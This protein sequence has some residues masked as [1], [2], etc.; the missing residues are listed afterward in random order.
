MVKPGADLSAVKLH[1]GGEIKKIKLDANGNLLIKS[2]AGTT[3]ET[4]PVTYYGDKL[5]ETK[6]SI[7]QVKSSYALKG[8]ELVFALPDGYDHSQSIV[9]DPFVSNTATL[10]GTGVNAGIAK[11]VDY[12]YA[13]NVYVTGGGDGSIYKLAKFDANGVLQWT[14][15]GA[16]TIPSW[17][18]GTIYGGWVVEKTTGNVYLGQGF[19]PSGGHRVIRI[20]TIGVYDNYITNANPSF[21]EN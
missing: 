12:D 6:D 7:Q 20:N 17:N 14:F 21:L 8:K 5:R 10:T 11:D 9:I 4:I 18:F 1:F 2:A 3:I 19:A 16:L 15:N 13:G